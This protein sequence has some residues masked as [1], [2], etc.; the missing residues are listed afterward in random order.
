MK[1]WIKIAVLLTIVI[2]LAVSV[3]FIDS[4]P[5]SQYVTAT[6]DGKKFIKWM[7]FNVPYSALSKAMNIDIKSFGTATK[8]DW[9]EML[10]YLAAKYGGNWKLYKSKDMDK[11]TE[12]L[13]KGEQMTELTK[14]MK[15]F[16]YF[17]ECYNAVLGEFLGETE[18]ETPNPMKS[19]TKIVKR[20]YG[21]KVFSPFAK[22][23]YYSHSDDF[24]NRRTFG[25][26]RGHMGNDL[27][28]SVGTPIVAVESGI[29]E[30]MGWNMYGGWRIGIRSFDRK[31][32]YYYAHLRKGHPFQST[33]KEGDTVKAGD[34][35]GYLG[36]TGY[37]TK[38]DT[39]GMKVPHLHFG[40]Q[41]IFD[42]SQKECNNE[43]WID[44]YQIIN[45][46]EKSRSAVSKNQETKEYNRVYD[47]N[48]VN[49]I[50]QTFGE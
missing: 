34:V 19:D 46:L 26:T 7:E 12:R 47:F 21:L 3:P 48:E 25:F 31:R 4:D 11:L 23:Y 40:M 5:Q 36:M 9:I 30:V 39:N 8:I 43:L 2:S 42:E 27:V 44:V 24:G 13:N 33:L 22:N 20:N 49:V 10:A 45:L 29:I 15:N 6:P 41:L 35:I 50:K 16:N 17:Y 1:K 18:M 28:G 32:Y 14:N 38:E 37:S